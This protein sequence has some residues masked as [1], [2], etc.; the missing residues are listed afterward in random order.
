MRGRVYC[1]TGFFG[2]NPSC[3]VQ[4]TSSTGEGVQADYCILPII[5]D[6]ALSLLYLRITQRLFPA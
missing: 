4:A 5:Q 2:L 1:V 6:K 3:Q